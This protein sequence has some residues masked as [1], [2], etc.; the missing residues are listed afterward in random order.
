MIKKKYLSITL[1]LL[2]LIVSITGIYAISCD[3][4]N[5]CPGNTW[6]ESDTS[7]IAERYVCV[8]DECVLETKE[9]DCTSNNECG[10]NERCNEFF[11]CVLSSSVSPGEEG[12]D[13]TNSD[14]ENNYLLP[15]LIIGIAV[16][17]GFIIL[18]VVLKK[19]N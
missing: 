4:F 6:H 18:A 5:P 16:I 7:G 3:S 17:I 8:N 14:I 1:F 12:K 9:V 15:S 11:N 10:T 13:I 19:R 2:I